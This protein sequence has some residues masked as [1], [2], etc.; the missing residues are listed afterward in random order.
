MY[1]QKVR[2]WND[3]VR[4]VLYK[5]KIFRMFRLESDANNYHGLAEMMGIGV[6]ARKNNMNF[7]P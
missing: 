1:T 3:N 4:Y 7:I 2:F 6:K 5:Y